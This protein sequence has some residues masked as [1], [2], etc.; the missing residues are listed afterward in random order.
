MSTELNGVIKAGLQALFATGVFSVTFIKA[1][2]YLRTLKVTLDP[3]YVPA[4]EPAEGKGTRASNDN[5]AIV[6]DMD[7]GQWKSF[8]I[9]SLVSISKVYE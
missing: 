3:E 7:A 5:V 2:G 8:K 1:D 9:D 4:A 6:Y